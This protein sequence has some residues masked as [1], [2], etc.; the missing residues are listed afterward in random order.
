M[1]GN[2]PRGEVGEVPRPGVE[3]LLKMLGDTKADGRADAKNA[4]ARKTR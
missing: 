2:I 3:K 4:K 1:L